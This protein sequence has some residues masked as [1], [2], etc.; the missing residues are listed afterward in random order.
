MQTLILHK[1]TIVIY[2]LQQQ[3]LHYN[4]TLLMQMKC[5]Q[6]AVASAAAAPVIPDKKNHIRP[7]LKL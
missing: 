7:I 2:Q 5:V 4:A 1:K 3:D 6:C